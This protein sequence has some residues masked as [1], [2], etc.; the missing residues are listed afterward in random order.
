MKRNAS[1]VYFFGSAVVSNSKGCLDVQLHVFQSRLLK[2]QGTGVSLRVSV[3]SPTT[4]RSRNRAFGEKPMYRLERLGYIPLR[5]FLNTL[6][7]LHT[8]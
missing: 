2:I 1:L 8:F 4:S 5:W 6:V 7:H 3:V